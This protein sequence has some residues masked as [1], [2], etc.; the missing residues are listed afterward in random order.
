MKKT[1]AFNLEMFKNGVAAQ[2]KLG[3]RVKFICMTNDNKLFIKVY[4]RN[5][6]VGFSEKHI[7]PGDPEGTT[8]KYNLNG[9]KYA[10]TPTLM[11][12]EMVNPYT[13]NQPRDA[14]GRF[15]KK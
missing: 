9:T 1:N 4:H 8:Y 10:G 15:I 2:T 6:I 12:L 7:A 13:I 11:D 3:N 14:K 5:R